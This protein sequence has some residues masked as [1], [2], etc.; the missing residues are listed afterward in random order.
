M[1]VG[2]PGAGIGGLFYL[3]CALAMPVREAWRIARGRS[4]AERRREAARQGTIAL[5]ILGSLWLTAWVVGRILLVLLGGAGGAV[6]AGMAEESELPRI[7]S[8]PALLT[9]LG[10]LGM[11]LLIVQVLRL[12]SRHRSG[13][14][15]AAVLLCMFT[16]QSPPAADIASPA[17]EFRSEAGLDSEGHL[18][19]RTGGG[20][21]IPVAD[22]WVAGVLFGH[23]RVSGESGAVEGLDARLTARWMPRPRLRADIEAG[24]LHVRDGDPEN[25]RATGHVR[26]R[27]SAPGNAWRLDVRADRRPL[28]VTP[29]LF[30][31]GIMRDEITVRPEVSP[32]TGFR[33]RATGRASRFTG[34]GETNYRTMAGGG[35]GWS[36]TPWVEFNAHAARTQFA[37][38]AS[39][40]YFAPER[41]E[42]AEVGT[43]MEFEGDR[44]VLAF[45]GGAG[46]E[47]FRE[48]GAGF[49]PWRPAFRAYLLL[50]RRL[51]EK[52]RLVLEADA[53]DSRAELSAAG[54]EGW[55]SVTAGASL[56][57]ALR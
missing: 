32:V 57:R 2:I 24:A 14:G 31:D 56:R 51:G 12:L 10:T 8:V 29:Q 54:G 9:G 27:A 11:I 40:G 37:R 53:Y 7:L 50:A 21:D 25:L 39:T 5:G 19:V 55:R 17:V 26:F 48:H 18:V 28:D 3:L 33:L 42:A 20:G 4:T 30:R 52:T 15:V 38:A 34:G 41:V 1:A 22:S 35:A 44:Y 47:R 36:P 45:D 16:L 23:S 13:G 46:F 6:A 43:Y 49:E